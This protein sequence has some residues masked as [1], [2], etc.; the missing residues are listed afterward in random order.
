[1]VITRNAGNIGICSCK[2]GACRKCGSTCKRCKCACDG[3]LPIDA[4]EQNRGRP[5][6]RKRKVDK[7]VKQVEKHAL[8]PR[9]KKMNCVT[10]KK[11]KSN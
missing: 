9:R 2:V 7:N 8:R 5:F 11:K 6:K 10:S 3:I 4:L 1:M